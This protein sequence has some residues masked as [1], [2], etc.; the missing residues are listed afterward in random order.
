MVDLRPSPAVR[1]RDTSVRQAHRASQ[2]ARYFSSAQPLTV[3]WTRLA[4][5]PT[6]GFAP[7]HLVA[8]EDERGFTLGLGIVTHYD[9]KAR[10][11]TLYT[12]LESLAGVD[13]LRLGNLT[14]DSKTFQ[15]QRLEG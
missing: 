7:N 11:V 2:F 5:F 4:V 8:V 14:L 3:T 1:S 6:L 15:E 10:Q 13:A 9:V 12:P